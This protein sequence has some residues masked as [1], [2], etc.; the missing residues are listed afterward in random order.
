MKK[1]FLSLCILLYAC[2]SSVALFACET[3]SPDNDYNYDYTNTEL[4][5]S[6]SQQFAPCSLQEFVMHNKHA[7]KYFEFALSHEYILNTWETVT[8]NG[9][10][11]KEK[12][13]T[14]KL[15]EGQYD[16]VLQSCKFYEQSELF[17]NYQSKTLTVAVN[18]SQS[19]DDL[20]PD[21]D[22]LAEE[23]VIKDRQ[24][25]APCYFN[26][27]VNFNPYTK[28]YFEFWLASSVRLLS[29][30]KVI[31]NGKEWSRIEQTTNEL[32]VGI[33]D[34]I[35]E[36]ENGTIQKFDENGNV[37]KLPYNRKITIPVSVSHIQKDLYIKLE[38]RG[39]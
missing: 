2:L 23:L 3:F 5:I 34:I 28:Q 24:Y 39:K 35:I 9:E 18:V 10:D 17:P 1:F 33:Y 15:P 27:F 29:W 37:V 12:R 32:P 13:F 20:A 30:S 6:E 38:E 26:E 22:Y 7:S 21:Y 11:W 31:I 36:V 4:T 19:F 25:F 16:I 14:E 8:V